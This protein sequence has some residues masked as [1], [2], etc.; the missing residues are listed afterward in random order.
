MEL[1]SCVIHYAKGLPLGLAIIGSNLCG[2]TKL[3]WKSEIDKYEKIL[4]EDIQ[5]ILKVSYDGLEETEKETFLDIACF[6]KEWYMDY[7]VDILDTCD[8]YPNFGIPILV[9]KSLKN[10]DQ[11]ATL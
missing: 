7:V 6:F 4:K 2:R 11:N 5:E 10:V 8:L 3:E 9:N 1:A